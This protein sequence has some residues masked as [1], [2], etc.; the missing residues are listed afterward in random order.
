M[1]HEAVESNRDKS[2]LLSRP[3]VHILDRD[4]VKNRSRQTS[5][6][7]MGKSGKENTSSQDM[8]RKVSENLI[9]FKTP[10]VKYRTS[11]VHFK[12]FDDW[13]KARKMKCDTVLKD[14]SSFV[15]EKKE[16]WPPMRSY[17][18][19]RQPNSRWTKS[20][21]D[22]QTSRTSPI[23]REEISMGDYHSRRESTMEH[24][25][26]F[27]MEQN[28]VSPELQRW[29][30]ASNSQRGKDSKQNCYSSTPLRE[31]FIAKE[32]K[33]LKSDRNDSFQ[34]PRS[35]TEEESDHQRH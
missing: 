34:D 26:E 4:L 25:G 21:G 11:R 31:C 18:S 2:W 35:E 22:P 28:R 33:K 30:M 10:D 6:K 14:V 20:N 17:P 29:E 27:T 7:T 13:V 5:F 15:S 3:L 12:T 1:V 9:P 23:D 16:D 19:C 8:V 24:R 32:A